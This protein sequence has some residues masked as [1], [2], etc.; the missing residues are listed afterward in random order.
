MPRR[1]RRT[2]PRDLEAQV[3]DELDRE[4]DELIP[5]IAAEEGLARGATRVSPEKEVELW[6][7][8]DPRVDRDSLKAMLMQGQVPPEWFDEQSD[9]RLALIRAHPEMAQ[10]FAEPLDDEMSDI[11]ADLAEWPHR[12]S[13][14]KPYEDDPK[15]SVAKA[16]S[17]SRRWQRQMGTVMPAAPAPPSPVVPSEP[18]DTPEPTIADPYTLAARMGG[19]A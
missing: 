16:D 14:L 11:V 10:M 9:Q 8:R 12:L 2:T 19:G 6:G 17:V 18:T 7:Q 4:L 13:V 1:S 3:W 5:V 15:A